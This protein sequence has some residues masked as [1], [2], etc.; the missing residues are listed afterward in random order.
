MRYTLQGVTL[1]EY[2]ELKK[3]EQ[4]FNGHLEIRTTF[5]YSPSKNALGIFI[6]RGKKQKLILRPDGLT[7]KEKATVENL[8]LNLEQRLYHLRLLK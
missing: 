5:L 3:Q 1:E 8:Y 6:E 2:V 4:D 7:E